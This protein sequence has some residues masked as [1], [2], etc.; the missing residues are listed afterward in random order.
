V[1]GE[2]SAPPL[3]PSI[4]APFITSVGEVAYEW[5][6]DTDAISWG[7]NVGEVLG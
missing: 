1:V 6:V 3:S 5:R 7:A 2:P 4:M